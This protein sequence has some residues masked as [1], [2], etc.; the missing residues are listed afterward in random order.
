[1]KKYFL[2]AVYIFGCAQGDVSAQ[3][4]YPCEI[5]LS[6]KAQSLYDKARAAQKKNETGR[7]K[8]DAPV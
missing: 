1:M 6:K 3:K 7:A 8:A 4:N 2:I 5:T